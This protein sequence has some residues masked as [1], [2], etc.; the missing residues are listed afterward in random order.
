MSAIHSDKKKES[1]RKIA[2]FPNYKVSSKGRI[3]SQ[4][5][6]MT[7]YTTKNGYQQI[8]LFS[9]TECAEHIGGNKSGVSAS[10][11]GRS[12]SYKGLHFEEI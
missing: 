7:P 11:C 12:K 3:K 8:R 6:I 2:S 9:N 5:T 1:W 4:R 10:L